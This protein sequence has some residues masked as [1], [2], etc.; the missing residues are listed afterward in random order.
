MSE[1]K[2][3]SIKNIRPLTFAMVVKEQNDCATY[4]AISSGRH[5]FLARSEGDARFR[6][7][8]EDCLYQ[9]MQEAEE[10]SVRRNEKKKEYH[11]ESEEKIADILK[12][13]QIRARFLVEEGFN[14]EFVN[15]WLEKQ[16][17]KARE[18]V[19][20]DYK[21]KCY[22]LAKPKSSENDDKRCM[23]PVAN[24]TGNEIGKGL[25]SFDRRLLLNK[26]LLRGQT[27]MRPAMSR[28][29]R[30]TNDTFIN[31]QNLFQELNDEV[32]QI[33]TGQAD[34]E[35]II[36]ANDERTN[37]ILT[38]DQNLF[39]EIDDGHNAFFEPGLVSELST[40]ANQN[41]PSITK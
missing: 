23:S 11:L 31:D 26:K 21:K 36:Q 7:F 20:N 25:L 24:M 38:N 13:F 41:G 5:Y 40:A 8:A 19:I 18:E 3:D 6:T 14:E 2:R 12:E 37:D 33:T 35:E 29:F 10:E 4:A 39:Q 16:F 22:L 32:T 1:S 27:M 17:K 15:E 9:T 28:T 34:D 30:R